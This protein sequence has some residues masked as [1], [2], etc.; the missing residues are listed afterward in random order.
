M[1]Q[2]LLKKQATSIDKYT[3]VETLKHKKGDW[4]IIQSEHNDQRYFLNKSTTN[5]KKDAMLL[6]E[7]NESKMTHSMDH[8]QR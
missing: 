3:V 6:C 7:A 2:H 5:S 1:S 4:F 8:V